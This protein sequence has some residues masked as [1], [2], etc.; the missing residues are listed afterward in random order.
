MLPFHLSL[1]NHARDAAA[2]L[3]SAGLPSAAALRVVD[4]ATA[5]ATQVPHA[6]PSSLREFA[7]FA[8]LLFT[9]LERGW[10]A[11]EAALLSWRQAFGLPSDCV[12][13]VR[14]L[15]CNLPDASAWPL[16]WPAALGIH[17]LVDSNIATGLLR[18]AA[19]LEASIP[20]AGDPLLRSALGLFLDATSPMD[21]RLRAIFLHTMPI[22]ELLSLASA[23]AERV[24]SHISLTLL[25]LARA[26]SASAWP[27]RPGAGP[28]V[29]EAPV[30]RDAGIC[31]KD[32]CG[33]MESEEQR[34]SAAALFALES[35]WASVRQAAWASEKLAA[36]SAGS[37]HA[38]SV[39]SHLDTALTRAASPAERARR[40]PAHPA[41]DAAPHVLAAA[42]ALEQAACDA[43]AS[44]LAPTMQADARALLP[45]ARDA[46]AL[47][48]LSLLAGARRN[49]FLN[50][51]GD[52]PASATLPIE[53]L[54]LAWLGLR[55]AL[56]ALCSRVSGSE[57]AAVA[58]SA[59]ALMDSCFGMS[60]LASTKPLL[61]RS[62]GHP[63]LPAQGEM[64]VKESELRLLCDSSSL[65]HEP[66]LRSA[67]AQAACFFAWSH[68][69]VAGAPPFTLSVAA[70][71][72]QTAC[73]RFAAV[74]HSEEPL[75]LS[76]A[77]PSEAEHGAMLDACDSPQ[78]ESSALAVPWKLQRWASYASS[79][80][81]LR[82]LAT[83][84]S[85][86]AAIPLLASLS[87]SVLRPAE[88]GAATVASMMPDLMR[89][90]QHALAATG[91]SPLDCAP[92]QQLSWLSERSQDDSAALMLLASA[93]PSTVHE[94]WF[95]QH[96]AVWRCHEPGVAS[97]WTHAPGPIA[98]MRPARTAHLV[99]MAQAASSANVTSRSAVL[100]QLRLAARSVRALDAS[101][102]VGL[103]GVEAN[104][105]CALVA[106]LLRAYDGILPALM[107]PAELVARGQ[108]AEAVAALR[109]SA[110]CG[111]VP[112]PLAALLMPLLESL[113]VDGHPP[114]S[115]EEEA[116]RGTTWARLGAARLALLSAE[117]IADPAARDAFKLST[118][119]S[120]RQDELIPECQLRAAST[121]LPGA[122]PFMRALRSACAALT[123]ADERLKKLTTRAVPRPVP[124]VWLA[125][126]AE[127]ERASAGFGC[128]SPCASHC[129]FRPF[130]SPVE[131]KDDNMA[132][133]FSVTRTI[134][135]THSERCRCALVSMLCNAPAG[136]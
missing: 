24:S 123:A 14:S 82:I 98:L 109:S 29:D 44:L 39:L 11:S 91:R 76:A 79:A 93:L 17:R 102:Q 87:F 133:H 32:D 121:V 7:V 70:E 69:G 42:A 108:L 33:V 65:A 46:S 71:V 130:P 94:L 75:T 113:A 122:L 34:A 2:L 135:P 128:V 56:S 30:D 55:K 21:F 4:L 5:Q 90:L 13:S 58:I 83:L 47:A 43:G 127:V 95:R 28:Y 49:V 52:T 20:H 27:L 106:Q 78:A 73:E 80:A 31:D 63:M 96:V 57:A 117:L 74:R 6:R 89:L 10:S 53:S 68:V 112:A 40:A 19:L 115:P 1:T 12:A 8:Q 62:A 18:E 48:N 100:L 9:L 105:L 3:C 125:A 88:E 25:P 111:S 124:S 131:R 72:L 103:A 37:S 99:G 23:V 84:T 126:R 66:E 61:W 51:L 101:V 134:P 50:L 16:L 120:C 110:E 119:K 45:A 81:G 116:A 54:L 64:V 77:C 59:A 67:L 35:L 104:A 129:P 26:R 132:V 107:S 38:E 41:L 22:S 85:L 36:I 114:G 97:C 60:S 86:A 92:L 118:L 136:G 15:P